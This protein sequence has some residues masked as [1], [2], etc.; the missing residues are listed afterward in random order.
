LITLANWSDFDSAI[1]KFESW[2]PSRVFPSEFNNLERKN[3]AGTAPFMSL[4]V[5][6][7][8]QVFSR[9]PI[10]CQRLHATWMQHGAAISGNELLAT[11]MPKCAR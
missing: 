1:L 3:I 4:Y 2:R 9:L 10:L 7:N 8:L 5:A 6:K 11:P